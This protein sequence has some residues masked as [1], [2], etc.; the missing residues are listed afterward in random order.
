MATSA[1]TLLTLL[2]VDSW[3]PVDNGRHA[4]G[5]GDGS[6]L[7]QFTYGDCR[8]DFTDPFSGNDTSITLSNWSLGTI[9][10]LLAHIQTMTSIASVK[11][12]V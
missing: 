7:V 11:R 2:G 1:E 10:A 5:L 9:Q 4:I 8:I 3:Q 12:E 6:I